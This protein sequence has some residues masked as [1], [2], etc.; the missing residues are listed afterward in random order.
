MVDLALEN[1]MADQSRNR[2]SVP[3]VAYYYRRSLS[4]SEVLPAIGAA[5]GAAAAAF[6]LARLVLQKT[7]LVRVPGIDQVD[8]H[9]VLVR[10]SRPGPLDERSRPGS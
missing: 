10:Q 9:G 2:A 6:Y 7:P 5:I 4:R 3:A 8:E 1:P